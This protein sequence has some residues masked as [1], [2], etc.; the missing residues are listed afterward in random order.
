LAWRAYQSLAQL[1][2]LALLQQVS[3]LVLL[4]FAL[5][6]FH[7]AAQRE[8]LFLKMRAALLELILLVDHLLDL[9]LGE[10]LAR[11]HVDHVLLP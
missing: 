2:D 1:L 4:L 5:V 6:L 8:I 10:S 7:C 9:R 3:A 11:R